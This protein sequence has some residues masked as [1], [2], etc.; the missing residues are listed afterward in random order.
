ML[1]QSLKLII[2]NANAIVGPYQS[3]AETVELLNEQ[4]VPVISPLSKDVGTL[5]IIYIKP[6]PLAKL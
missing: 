1:L 6:Y 5:L 4:N 2:L 3:N